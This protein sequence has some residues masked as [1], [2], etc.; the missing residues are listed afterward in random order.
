MWNNDEG[1]RR[2]VSYER[3]GATTKTKLKAAC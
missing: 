2:E 3:L 1:R